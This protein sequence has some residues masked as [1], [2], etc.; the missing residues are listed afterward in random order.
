[1]YMVSWGA[2]GKIDEKQTVTS[3]RDFFCLS[4]FR[5]FF[6]WRNERAREIAACEVPFLGD[7]SVA[8]KLFFVPFFCFRETKES[9]ERWSMDNDEHCKSESL[10][11]QA[12]IGSNMCRGGGAIEIPRFQ[13]ARESF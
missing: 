13:S 2:L 5:R 3:D 6:S 7:F 4:S 11:E 1:M 12:W 8:P 10:P 9:K